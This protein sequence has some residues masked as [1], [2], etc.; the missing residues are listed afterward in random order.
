M[1]EIVSWIQ[2]NWYELG[3]LFVEFAFL[4]AGVW[5]ARNVLRTMRSFQEQVG[6]ILKLS[7][8]ANPADRQSAGASAGQH[9]ADASP[10]W[11]APSIASETQAA[12]LPE[13]RE[14]GPGRF[15]VAGHRLVLWLN[16]PMSKP[17]VPVWRKAVRWLQSPAR[18]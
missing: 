9:L 16:A 6:A 3:K 8:T 4:A 11:L 13:V 15:A 2:A 17:G 12:S 18:S 5:F 1:G 10:Y 14:S 7:M